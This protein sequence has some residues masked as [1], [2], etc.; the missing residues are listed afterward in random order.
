GLLAAADDTGFVANYGRRE[1]RSSSSDPYV[2]WVDNVLHN[3]G[4]PLTAGSLP[5]YGLGGNSRASDVIPPWLGQIA[6]EAAD[7]LMHFY[8]ALPF[9]VAGAMLPVAFA[10]LL[11]AAEA[12]V[13]GAVFGSD[14]LARDMTMGF[15][16]GAHFLMAD[17]SVHFPQLQRR[18]DPARARQPRRRRTRRRRTLTKWH[19]WH[20]GNLDRTHQR[21]PSPGV[22]NNAR[23]TNELRRRVPSA[24]VQRRTQN[25]SFRGIAPKT[26]KNR[27]SRCCTEG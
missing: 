5:L 10:P 1:F 4:E 6:D 24:G 18:P 21:R 22:R 27:R 11:G 9:I 17:G 13:Q 7:A 19:A 14:N 12:G 25:S 8:I 20:F 3:N 26:K 16:G 2:Q 15:V 23:R